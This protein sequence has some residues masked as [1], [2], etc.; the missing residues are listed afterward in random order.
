MKEGWERKNLPITLNLSELNE[1]I[2]PAL[3]GKRV[4][5][6]ERIGTGLSNSNYKIHLEGCVKPYVVRFF[7]SGKEIA[8]KE[9][10]IT[11]LVQQTVPVADFIYVDTSCSRFD[12]SWAVLEWKEGFLLRDVFRS[13][14]LQD[15]TSAAVSVGRVLAN[16][17]SYHFTESGFFG[18]DL[19][20]NHPLM[21]DG[22]RFLSFMEQIL[23][24]DQCGKWL[25]KEL[26]QELWSF[27]K[28]YGP[29]LSESSKM[30][31]LVHSDFNGL[32]ILMKYGPTG[33][34]VSS[35][36]DW[37]EAFSWSRHV[38]IGNMLRYEEDGSIFE[39]HFI[40]AYQEQGA[41]LEDNWKLLSKLEDLVALCDMLNNSTIDT[42]NR[43]QDLQRLV[44]RTVQTFG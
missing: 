30:P 39:E 8:D 3:P 13:G 10:A 32:N 36:L 5:T 29:L 37:E 2:R 41:I 35:V 4:I 27:C 31:V 22:D 40:Q 26:T 11:Q 25:G 23:F 16:I 14:T 42:P 33:C 17:H 24:H 38:D 19:K 20:I 7:R 21:M 28:T 18:K 15:I 9:L 34:S 6:A 43:M 1:I 12:K 44:A